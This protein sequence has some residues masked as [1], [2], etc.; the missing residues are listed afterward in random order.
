[1][2]TGTKMK[3]LGALALA[4]CLTMAGGYGYY[5]YY[6]YTPAGHAKVE[7]EARE[8]ATNLG[9]Q[10]TGIASRN[11]DLGGDGYASV[12][13]EAKKDGQD[14]RMSIQC[15]APKLVMLSWGCRENSISINNLAK[16]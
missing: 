14:H 15:V 5:K 1:M 11:D 13:I 10:V 6:P 7:R 2:K 4:G 16:P 8:W 9:Y 12:T 3:W